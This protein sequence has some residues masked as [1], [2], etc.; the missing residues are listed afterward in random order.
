[1]MPGIRGFP[2]LK[3]GGPQPVLN[4]IEITDLL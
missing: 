4:M 3:P 1:M 2:K